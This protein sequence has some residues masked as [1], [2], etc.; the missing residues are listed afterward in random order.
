MKYTVLVS[1]PQLHKEKTGIIA[2]HIQSFPSNDFEYAVGT[3]IFLTDA[4]G[5][6]IGETVENSTLRHVAYSCADNGL[7]RRYLLIK[8][9]VG[10]IVSRDVIEVEGL[11]YETL[12]FEKSDLVVDYENRRRLIEQLYPEYL[13]I[14]DDCVV[15]KEGKLSRAEK[16]DYM[17][18]D[19]DQTG[20]AQLLSIVKRS[21]SK[22]LITIDDQNGNDD[23][24]DKVDTVIIPDAESI[25]AVHITD[26][27][28]SEKDFTPDQMMR[29]CFP[30]CAIHTRTAVTHRPETLPQKLER[31]Y[32]EAQMNKALG[33][34]N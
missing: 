7:E 26:P 13:I 6:K 21:E 33:R 28:P 15:I 24:S 1:T 32:Q 14:E 23:I 2:N 22:S 11:V 3:Q 5:L 18:I 34:D 17:I 19:Y 9:I 20:K 12:T 25:P 31:E 27:L 8:P 10:E 30:G 29:D 4:G 16:G